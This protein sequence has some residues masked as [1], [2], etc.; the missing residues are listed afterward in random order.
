MMLRKGLYVVIAYRPFLN[1]RLHVGEKRLLL[2]LHVAAY[3]MGVLVIELQDEA[4]HMV[5]D[6][7]AF[8]ELAPYERQLEVKKILMAGFQIMH[9]RRNVEEFIFLK[10]AIPINGEVHDGQKGIGVHAIVLTGLTNG[11]IAKAE[12]D[13]ERA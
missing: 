7:N 6:I 9:E 11:F 3:L 5:C 12:V 1:K 2:V 4:S 8:L 10:V 13:A